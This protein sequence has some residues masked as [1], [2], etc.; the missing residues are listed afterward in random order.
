MKEGVGIIV[1]IKVSILAW[2][3]VLEQWLEIGIAFFTFVLVSWSVYDKINK[4]LGRGHG[5]SKGSDT[6][7]S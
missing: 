6:T 1:G 3:D 7:G 5:N 4:V 2:L